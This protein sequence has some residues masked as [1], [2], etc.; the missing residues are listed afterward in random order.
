MPQDS[1]SFASYASKVTPLR[2]PNTYPKVLSRE[3]GRGKAP[4]A[5]WMSVIKGHGHGIFINQTPQDS[6]NAIV[7]PTPAHK[8]CMPRQN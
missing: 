8:I 1:T 7:P 2:R 3:R 5:N 4:L 6:E